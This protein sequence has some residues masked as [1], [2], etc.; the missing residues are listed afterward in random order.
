MVDV[1]P[2]VQFVSLFCALFWSTLFLMPLKAAH[3]ASDGRLVV[4]RIFL[5]NILAGLA[6]RKVRRNG[7]NLVVDVD[8]QAAIVGGPAVSAALVGVLVA[9][10]VGQPG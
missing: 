8:G 7:P 4:R 1:V 9:P 5:G 3:Y 2:L 6:A 10:W